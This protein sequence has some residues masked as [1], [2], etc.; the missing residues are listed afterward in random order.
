MHRQRFLTITTSGN[1]ARFFTQIASQVQTNPPD[2]PA[3]IRIAAVHDIE[4][5]G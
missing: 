5:A 1:A 2:I 4:F 3:I